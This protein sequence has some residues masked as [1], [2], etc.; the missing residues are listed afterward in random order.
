MI[1]FEP[2]ET[3]LQ[4]RAANDQK[5]A[6]SMV[7]TYVISEEMAE[8]LADVVIP[9]LQFSDPRDNK[10]V[11]VVGNYGTGKSHLM[12]V[13]SGVAEHSDLAQYISHPKVAEAAKKI[14]GKFKV[15]RAE[16]SAASEMSLRDIVTSIL[17]KELSELGV[18][19]IFPAADQVSNHKICF[20]DMMAEFHQSFPD[21]G[22]LF[23]VDELLDYLD[24]RN[25]Q[26]VVQDLGFMREMAESC[27]ELRFRYMA[28]VQEAIFDSHRFQFVSDRLRRVKDRFEQVFIARNDI[29]FVVAERL[30]HKTVDQQAN[31]R[32]Y[33]TPFAKFYSNMNERM[34]EF[35]RLFPVHP[36]YI[37][38]FER[39]S[40]IE[41]RQI[42]KSLSISMNK[43]LK[44][45]VPKDYPG[46]IAY[47]SYWKELSSDASYRTLPDIRQVIDVSSILQERIER[48]L[49]RPAYKNM[50]RR[51]IDAL[52]LH[53]LTMNDIHAS[54]GA[55]AHE[56]RDTLCLYQ[57]G[58]EDLGGDPAEDLL[59]QVE[60]VL[61]E[62]HKTVSGQFISANPDNHQYYLDLK[63]TDDFDA[64]IEQKAET[65]SPDAL[66]R[67]YHKAL[68]NILECS[69]LPQT[70]YR[71]LW[72]NEIEWRERKTA[73]MGWLFFGTPRERSTAYPPRD[74]YLYFIQPF[75]TPKAKDDKLPDEVQ[76]YL[77]GY[78]QDFKKYLE[79]YAA[80]QDLA[81]TASGHA[82]ITYE[83]KSL[84]FQKQINR[85][86]LEQMTTAFE[87]Q[88]QGKR[89]ALLEWVKGKNL[90]DLAG[91]S[92]Q[93]RINFRDMVN[94]VSGV[95]LETH[96]ADIAPD[97]P[98]FSVL[99]T[100]KN[101][102]QYAKDAIRVIAGG[103]STKQATAVLDALD[104]LDGD[105]LKPADSKYTKSILDK[106]K[107]KPHGQV[108]NRAEIIETVKGI[109]YLEP[110]T[111]RLESEWV[112]VLMAS[113]I[114]SGDIVLAVPGNKL[115]ASKLSDMA[116]MPVDDLAAFKHIE[117]PKDWN[118]PGLTALFELLDL[119]PALAI[120]ISQGRDGSIAL[121]QEHVSSAVTRLVAM[122]HS[123]RERMPFWGGMVLTESEAEQFKQ[124]LAQTKEFL[125]SLQAFNTTGKLKNF[126]Y[127]AEDV[128]AHQECL[129]RLAELEKLKNLVAELTPL[130]SYL[131][132]AEA[133]LPPES[134]WTGKV[135]A[136][137]T[138]VIHQLDSPK[139]RSSANFRHQVVGRLEQLKKEY[140][141]IYSSL[142]AKCR[143]T[144]S[145]DKR[146]AELLRDNRLDQLQALSTIDILRGSQL[147]E[148]RNNLASL[149]AAAPINS[150]DL[151]AD[152]V[153]GSIDFRPINE[154]L[155]VY[156]S[157]RL[158]TLEA[159]LDQIVASWTKSLLDNLRDPTTKESI[160]LLSDEDRAAIEGLN[161][162]GL[163]PDYVDEVLVK[164]LRQVL[165]G[166]IPVELYRNEVET[167]LFVEG[168]AATIGQLKQRLDEF[169]S[170]KCKGQDVSK[171]R[172]VLR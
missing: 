31:I 119:A 40:V 24:S 171:V 109:D 73:R 116:S 168:A 11:L 20:E 67:A 74:F 159:E 33:L 19:Y 115:D 122:I 10:A 157:E 18:N 76:F 105:R 148:Y 64:I 51:I 28:G 132:K 161:S 8:R 90:R 26:Q 89:K 135:K 75:D 167:A 91:L 21:H 27:T 143:L 22:L 127:S 108:L 118:L 100:S 92:A 147:T 138:D 46:V 154:D 72:G 136:V 35:V 163:L 43:I 25:E 61:R 59:S 162:A 98:K 104:L 85:W 71:N 164:A 14:A 6:E 62:I 13:M 137:R 102:E 54:V 133:V 97:Y 130:A 29:K 38:T 4:L 113:L 169:L 3:V 141:H 30:L 9:Q 150:A 42:L 45:D 125:E 114:Y 39:V 15:I 131:S 156:A 17:T 153:P 12:S 140:I 165:R 78:D 44:S 56:L 80:A 158:N 128:K 2:L 49:A 106:L 23:V 117:R 94:T 55:T 103:S 7:K 32:E 52:A 50:A 145:E 144:L 124:E 58:I 83:A 69:D 142:Y 151:Q 123:L 160:S 5:T 63:K 77:T 149:K 86:L 88:Y 126:K 47:D 110:E 129:N 93:E 152:P 1:K 36:D 120:E 111:K 79:H 37:D 166:L 155:S 121:M 101:R 34:D 53:R 41:K 87:I 48:S 139:E 60:T 16:V 146:K 65:L 107:Q 57:S 112:A 70:D 68:Y 96:F 66:N 172:V 99:V 95:L 84:Q 81:G 82:K 134:E 170:E